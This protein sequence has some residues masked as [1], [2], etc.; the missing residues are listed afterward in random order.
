MLRPMLSALSVWCLHAVTVC[1]F[2]LG[3][4]GEA[5]QDEFILNGSL[6]DL[7]NFFYV[8][9][10]SRKIKPTCLRT[11][12]MTFRRAN[13]TVGTFCPRN[14]T[15]E[16]GG[17]VLNLVGHQNSQYSALSAN[18]VLAIRLYS[19]SSYKRFNQPLR[20]N[21]KPHSFR[22]SV[23]ELDEGMRNL[24]AVV[25][26][27]NALEFSSEHLLYRCVCVCVYARCVCVCVRAHVF[28]YAKF[29]FFILFAAYVRRGVK[30]RSIDEAKLRKFEGLN[31]RP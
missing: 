13:I 30:A 19:T 26:K 1:K 25:A 24:R 28:I 5:M 16:T 4:R 23:Y 8:R 11:S 3:S 21:E 10:G 17:K 31:G 6:Q 22:M 14:M 29:L 9:Y 7:E 20:N 15:R 18:H 2:G 12:K 27:K